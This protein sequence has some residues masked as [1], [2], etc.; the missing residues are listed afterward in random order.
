M[1]PQRY[2]QNFVTLF[3]PWH[4]WAGM[5]VTIYVNIAPGLGWWP[6]TPPSTATII[7]LWA[8]FGLLALTDV[9]RSY[10]HA[11]MLSN[12]KIVVKLTQL[13]WR[14]ESIRCQGHDDGKTVP[15]PVQ[16]LYT[17]YAAE[18]RILESI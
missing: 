18:Q 2:G 10:L 3:K 16:T 9:I 17:E 6:Y 12:Q 11:I 7:L 5:L 8:C 4:L 15:E 13:N 14:D 1:T